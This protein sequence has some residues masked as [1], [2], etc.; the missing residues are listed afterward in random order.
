[1]HKFTWTR[2]KEGKKKY[3][4]LPFNDYCEIALVCHKKDSNTDLVYSVCLEVWRERRVGGKEGE[5][6]KRGGEGVL[7]IKKGKQE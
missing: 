4:K 5:G 2:N 7:K 3:P 1:M 6:E